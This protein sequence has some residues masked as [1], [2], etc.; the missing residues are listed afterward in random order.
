MFYEKTIKKYKE[1]LERGGNGEK[2]NMNGKGEINEVKVKKTK[3]NKNLR[4]MFYIR[5]EDEENN[6]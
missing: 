5:E 3:F 2:G 6:N 1:L 4:N